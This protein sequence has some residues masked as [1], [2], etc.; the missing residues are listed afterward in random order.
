MSSRREK[1]SVDI[2]GTPPPATRRTVLATRYPLTRYLP[3]GTPNLSVPDLDQQTTKFKMIAKKT[4]SC[5]DKVNTI[6]SFIQIWWES[7]LFE[8]LKKVYLD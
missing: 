1:L 4:H 3:L 7:S 8:F 2:M 5:N 6:D